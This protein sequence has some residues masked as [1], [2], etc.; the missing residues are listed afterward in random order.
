M[1][2]DKSTA[3]EAAAS[4]WGRGASPGFVRSWRAT[5]NA[6]EGAAA[7]HNDNV[8]VLDELGVVEAK[9]AA[10]AT[11][12]LAAGT[13]KGRS[14]RDGSLRSP[15]TW[16][17]LVLSTGEIRLS[18]KLRENGQR[19]MAGQAIRLIDV[20]AD[21]GKNLGI[22]DHAG[23]PGSAKALADAIKLAAR[24]H[25]GSAGPAF[26]AQLIEQGLEDVEAAV[27]AAIA[28]FQ[29]KV[30]PQ[31]ADG[32]VQRA[33]D[34]FG[35]IAAAGELARDFGLVPWDEGSATEAAAVCFQAWLLERGGTGAAEADEAIA[36]VR[37][38]IEAHG[39]S[40]FED[41]EETLSGRIINRAGYRQGQGTREQWLVLPETW[42]AEV[43]VGLDPSRTARILADRGM[44]LRA[45][46]G[47]QTVRKIAN[48]STRVYALTAKILAGGE[49]E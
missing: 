12:Q 22:F 11:Y 8:L 21:A 49:G 29:S 7:L 27:S 35:L 14:A 19:A 16:R 28:Q 20:P 10:A 3:V 13:G 5:A 39:Q 25:Y 18:D 9:E 23:E 31:G 32:Q 2:L 24:T 44:L 36:R 42:K 46:D 38:F 43:C 47:F 41:L 1:S 4:V 48:R 6:L 17:T 40:R 33:C 37:R 26:L 45:Q 15:L 34:R 30:V